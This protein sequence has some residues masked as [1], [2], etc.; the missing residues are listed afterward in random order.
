MCWRVIGNIKGLMYNKIHTA[1]Y[2]F[3]HATDQKG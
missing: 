2:G 3:N 1:T